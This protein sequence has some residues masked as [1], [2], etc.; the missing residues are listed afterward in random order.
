MPLASESIVGCAILTI[1]QDD[2]AV[3]LKDVLGQGQR[4]ILRMLAADHAAQPHTCA[5][6][7]TGPFA[8]SAIILALMMPAL[9]MLICIT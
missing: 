8:P 5:N 6:G 2:R 4:L 3:A 7:V 1:G 9:C